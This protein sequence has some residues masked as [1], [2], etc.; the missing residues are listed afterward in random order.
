MESI[1]IAIAAVIVESV[2]R[3]YFENKK[4][5]RANVSPPMISQ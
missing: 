5:I 1:A 3:W 4:A 2:M